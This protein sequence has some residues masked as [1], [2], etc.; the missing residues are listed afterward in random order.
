MPSSPLGP[1]TVS[2]SLFGGL[3]IADTLVDVGR[4]AKE[5]LPG[6]QAKIAPMLGAAKTKLA[7]VLGAAKNEARTVGA[8]AQLHPMAAGAIAGGAGVGAL[9]ALK[10]NN[11]GVSK[12]DNR[13]LT[14]GEKKRR[15]ASATAVGG[16]AGAAVGAAAG[17]REIRSAGRTD[18]LTRQAR[19]Q[20]RMH[21]D[22]GNRAVDRWD[23]TRA[24]EDIGAAK[25][26]QGMARA[27]HQ[28]AIDLSERSRGL[29]R[30]AGKRT[31]I[32][33]AVGAGALA[34]RAHYVN[35]DK[36]VSKSAF[37]VEHVI[38]KAD[39]DLKVYSRDAQEDYGKASLAIQ[40]G[41][42][43]GAGAYVGHK[44]ARNAGKFLKDPG[45]D[46]ADIPRATLHMHGGRAGMVAGAASAV[47]AGVYATKKIRS[48]NRKQKATDAAM[49]QMHR[50][51]E[52]GPV[53]KSA[54]GV[55]D[56]RIAKADAPRITRKVKRKLTAIGGTTGALV[57]TA[58]GGI[59]GESWKAAAVGGAIGGV[60]V[61][62]L[63]H[64]RST[65]Y[66]RN[67]GY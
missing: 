19:R 22:L 17:G 62:G 41:V 42:L 27:N 5:V 12:A 34:A 60:S 23:T 44:I 57:G 52:P 46:L 55:D 24:P 3:K 21:E 65:V 35:N 53:S 28:A 16:A 15:M 10:P 31:A 40:S 64:H 54:F 59:H 51:M 67:H 4:A 66:N 13:V 14:H 6:A 18:V 29:L 37:G 43:S 20:G 50:S 47:G 48:G 33:A 36:R 39:S 63:A 7:P 11:N 56:P 49:A 9:A 38:G 58:M 8:F 26:H 1:Q 32:G 30:V 2:K 61:G 25:I 45:G